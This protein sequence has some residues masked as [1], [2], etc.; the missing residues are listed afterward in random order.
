MASDKAT[1]YLPPKATALRLLTALYKDS[2]LQIE[3]S[4]VPVLETFF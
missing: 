3:H 2:S 4:T 1:L